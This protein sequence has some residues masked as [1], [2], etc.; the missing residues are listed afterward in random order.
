MSVSDD[1]VLLI[2]QYLDLEDFRLMFAAVYKSELRG[3][4]C[5]EIFQRTKKVIKKK[6]VF[7]S[8]CY[9]TKCFSKK[10]LEDVEEVYCFVH[11]NHEYLNT[12][13]NIWHNS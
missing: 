9:L 11:D 6:L 3:I 7:P 1:I 2:S 4:L 13:Y 5:E 8:S 10:E 12:V